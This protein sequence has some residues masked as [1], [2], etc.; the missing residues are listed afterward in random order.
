MVKKILFY[1]TYPTQSN[2]YAR[3]GNMLSNYLAE[4]N[5]LEIYY[6]GISNFDIKINRFINKKIKL[7]DVLVEEKKI[8]SE[9]IYGVD[10]INNFLES[11]KPDIFFIYNDIIVISRL[12]NSM[13][14]CKWKCKNIIYCDLVYDYQNYEMIKHVERHTD[15]IIVFSDWWKENLL[16]MNVNPSKLHVIPH[17]YDNRFFRINDKEKIKDIK[18]S[19]GFNEED[20]IILNS[21]RNNYRKCIDITIRAFLIFLKKFNLKKDI[22]LFLNCFFEVANGY[23]IFNL[24]KIECLRLDLDYNYIIYNHIFKFG[25]SGVISDSQLND[26]YNLCDIGVN[27]CG[28]EG[29]GLCNLEHACTGHPQIVSDVGGLHDI[30]KEHGNLIKPKSSFYIASIVDW[31]GG[32]F[33]ICD[34]EDFALAFEKYYLN[35][36]LIEEEGMKLEHDLLEK[37][38][39]KYFLNEFK[40]FF[41]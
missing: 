7:I 34:P 32:D 6:F 38:S 15:I 18:K 41:I 29:F 19:L 14:N 5:D 39:I 30:F 8:K 10:I 26:L 12:Y 13:I 36:N 27:T 3:I 23:D 24:V 25:N 16:R 20:F 31:H 35:R 17:G 37:Y 4:D 2:G 33:K 40:K 22:K 1:A 28:G 21:N 9:E 11:I